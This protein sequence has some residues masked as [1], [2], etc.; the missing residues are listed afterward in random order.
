MPSEVQ[1]GRKGL[2][3]FPVF[4]SQNRKQGYVN[5]GENKAVEI[6]WDLKVIEAFVFLRLGR[7]GYPLPLGSIGIIELARNSWQNREPKGLR[8]H[9][10]ENKGVTGFA[11]LGGPVASGSTIICAFLA[12]RKVRRHTV[13]QWKIMEPDFIQRA[14]FSSVFTLTE[15]YFGQDAHLEG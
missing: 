4:R 13:G 2:R 14:P 1:I 5:I 9:N 12:G 10:R 7:F 8:G 15:C 3:L 6:R 11:F